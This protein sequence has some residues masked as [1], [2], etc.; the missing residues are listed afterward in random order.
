MARHSKEL[1][2]YGALVEKVNPTHINRIPYEIATGVIGVILICLVGLDISK[3]M[4]WIG[5]ALIS[6]A[7]AVIFYLRLNQ[8]R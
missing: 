8:K 3:T 5:F 4:S 1:K 7:F 6:H 2:A